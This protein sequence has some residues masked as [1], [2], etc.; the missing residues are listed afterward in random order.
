MS[1]EDDTRPAARLTLLAGPAG[2]GKES[3]IELVRARSP[4]LWLSTPMTT[5]PRRAPEIDRPTH[6]FVTRAEFEALIAAGG[7]LEWG[8]YGDHLYGTPRDPVLTQLRAGRPALVP[9]DLA[10]ARQVRAAMPGTRLIYLVPPAAAAPAADL[11]ID[12]AV[13]NDFVE[14]AAEELVGL[15]GSSF[16]TPAQPRTSG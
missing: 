4:V 13:V 14:R 11:D 15:L 10:G 16:L 7:L 5:R 6:L 12:R 1:T 3:V 9:L 2:V 8:R